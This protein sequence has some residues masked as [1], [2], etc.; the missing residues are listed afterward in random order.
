M[1]AAGPWPDDKVGGGVPGWNDPSLLGPK[2]KMSWDGD[3]PMNPN[4]WDHPSKQPQKPLTKDLVW[5]SKQFRI[6]SDMGFKVSCPLSCLHFTTL[7]IL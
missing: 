7:Y 4:T 1:P 3:M 6:L 5:A 2:Y